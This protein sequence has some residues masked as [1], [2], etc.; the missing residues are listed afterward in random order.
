MFAYFFTAF[1]KCFFEGLLEHNC[2][3]LYLLFEIRMFVF[4]LHTYTKDFCKCKEPLKYLCLIWYVLKI[5]YQPLM[6]IIQWLLTHPQD[7]V[8]ITPSLRKLFLAPTSRSPI[9]R[10]RH[11]HLAALCNQSVSCLHGV[12]YAEYNKYTDSHNMCS[13]MIDFSLMAKC[14]QVQACLRMCYIPF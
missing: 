14:S 2:F 8:A 7:Q 11:C 1:T 6:S 3:V 4:Q 9:A 13:F 10:I 12:A 5:S